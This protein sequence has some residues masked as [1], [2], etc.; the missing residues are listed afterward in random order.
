MNTS[1]TRIQSRETFSIPGPTDVLAAGAAYGGICG[2]THA[3]LPDFTGETG[4]EETL[5]QLARCGR[6]LAEFQKQF[7]EQQYDDREDSEC[8][9]RH[10]IKAEWREARR[11]FRELRNDVKAV[12]YNRQSKKSGGSNRDFP[13]FGEFS[14]KAAEFERG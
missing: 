5:D 9:S 3:S 14:R 12:L 6:K 1:S 13:I 10:G 4:M 2:A 7:E 8:D 11:E